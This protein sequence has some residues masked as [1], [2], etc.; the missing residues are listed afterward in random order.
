MQLPVQKMDAAHETSKHKQIITTYKK[1]SDSI[2]TVRPFHLF[3][4]CYY[5]LNSGKY[6]LEI[7]SY[8]AASAIL[9]SAL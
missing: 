6:C 5:N 3:R 8:L 1:R 4:F 9:P 2:E 7:A